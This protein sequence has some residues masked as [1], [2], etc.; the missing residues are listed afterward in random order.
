MYVSVGGGATIQRR[1]WAAVFRRSH[2]HVQLRYAAT[3]VR[4]VTRRKSQGIIRT[5]E[6]LRANTPD[7]DVCDVGIYF[8][9]P[10]PPRTNPHQPSPL[11]SV[12]QHVGYGVTN[13]M[14]PSV[15][16]ALITTLEQGLGDQFTQLTKEAWTWVFGIIS[17]V[18]M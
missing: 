6:L 3:K 8:D 9:H 1:W 13:D 16:S 2:T 17:G 14:Y 15:G 4:G 5:N 10:L 18:C 7:S 11:R 12:Q